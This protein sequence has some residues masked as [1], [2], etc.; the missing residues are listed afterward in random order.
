MQ[1]QPRPLHKRPKLEDRVRHWNQKLTRRG[2]KIE[3]LKI[4]LKHPKIKIEME[5]N[6][7]RILPNHHNNLLLSKSLHEVLRSKN[8]LCTFYGLT[9]TKLRSILRP[10]HEPRP[11]FFKFLKFSGLSRVTTWQQFIL[12]P[13]SIPF[14]ANSASLELEVLTKILELKCLICNLS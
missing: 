5:M 9:A 14:L 10:S 11:N 3:R 13:W 4:F 12:L 7:L 1:Q 2:L 8:W 6:W